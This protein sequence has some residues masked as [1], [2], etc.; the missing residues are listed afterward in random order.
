M[1]NDTQE[2]WALHKIS[3]DREDPKDDYQKDVRNAGGHLERKKYN[4]GG[5]LE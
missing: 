2:K 4:F 1:D 5:F 3:H